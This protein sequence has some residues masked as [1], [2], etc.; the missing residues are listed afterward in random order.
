MQGKGGGIAAPRL[1]SASPPRFA[2]GGK[3]TTQCS[4]AGRAGQLHASTES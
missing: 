3:V 2:G 4:G 1:L